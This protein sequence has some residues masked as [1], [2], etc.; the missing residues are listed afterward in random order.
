MGLFDSWRRKRKSKATV[1]LQEPEKPKSVQDDTVETSVKDEAE[2]LVDLVAEY[3]RLVKRRE[4]LQVERGELTAK[5]DHDEINPDDFRKELMS[6][7]QEAATVSENL[8]IAAAKLTSQG[9]RGVLH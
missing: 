4:E 8:R 2:D 1:Q 5:L 7:I 9:Y 6:K 3:E